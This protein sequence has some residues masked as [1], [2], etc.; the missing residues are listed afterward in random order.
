MAERRR[1]RGSVLMLMPAAV[2]IVLLLGSI[3]VDFS[4]V[5]LRQRELYSAASA[6]A[7]D[8]ATYGV[9]EALFRA[10]KGYQLDPANVAKAAD[11]AFEARGFHRPEVDWQTGVVGTDEVEITATMDVPYV[12]AKAI[13]GVPHSQRVTVHVSAVAEQH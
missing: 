1:D 12:F 8:A 3:A 7:N 4:A 9:D 6:A 13:P 11:A 10:A 2:L 5:F